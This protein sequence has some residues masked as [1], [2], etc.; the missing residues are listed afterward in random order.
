MLKKSLMSDAKTHEY[1]LS[2]YPKDI[3][4]T[5][6]INTFII[7]NAPYKY[8]DLLKINNNITKKDVVT[9]IGCYI[10]NMF[11]FEKIRKD[12]PY[13]NGNWDK[14]LIGKINDTLAI[15]LLEK[16]I[17]TEQYMDI[18][19]RMQWLSMRFV[20][21]IAPSF[22]YNIHQPLPAVEKRKE[23]LFAQYSKEIAANDQ[24]IMIKIEEELLALARS[25]LN[26]LRPDGYELFESGV[27]SFENH[28]KN[29]SVMRGNIPRSS[30]TTEFNLV[31]SNLCDGVDKSE[32]HY[33]A[34]L[35]VLASFSRSVNTQTGG[36][37]VKKYMAGFQHLK[38]DKEGSNCGT[39]QALIIELTD[40]N[41]MEYHLRYIINGDGTFDILTT[42]NKD[43]YVGTK[44]KMRTPMYCLS[45]DIC[46]KCA[47]D[48]YYRMG[49]T[50]IGLL[51]SKIGSKL[52][53]A[54]LKFFHDVKTKV[55]KINIDTTNLKDI[56]MKEL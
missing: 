44:V 15:L 17:N 16:K 53:N 20:K 14:K 46:N 25:E 41:Y 23:E 29:V 26:K 45:N 40:K 37:L 33:F 24:M 28:Y 12:I 22:D 35:S 30:E 31:K 8:N 13:F 43:K 6:F 27:A 34:D 47:G 3:T 7:D 21:F 1:F 11:I 48:L 9:T 10:C 4:A 2:L 36:Y 55:T 5:W 42:E 56:S 38:L 49:V 54:S 19:D 51:T 18:L 50:N 32:I 52:L 39:K